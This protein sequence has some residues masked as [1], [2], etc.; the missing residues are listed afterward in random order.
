M[1]AAHP[2]YKVAVTKNPKKD[3]YEE[4]LSQVSA[5]RLRIESGNY[6]KDHP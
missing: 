5:K 6:R 4:P 1:G 3:V 2:S